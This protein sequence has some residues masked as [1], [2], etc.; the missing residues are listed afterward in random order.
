MSDVALE[1]EDASNDFYLKREKCAHIVKAA[2]SATI[3]NVLAPLLCIPMFQDEVRPAYFWAW[4]AYM[5]VVVCIRTLI[6]YRLGQRSEDI[7]D[8]TR[9][10]KQITFAVGIVGFGWGLG[11]PLMT[12]DLSMVD[13]MIY[14]YMTTAAM[15]SSMFA[16]SVNRPTFY[17]FTLPIMAPAM[18]TL[19]WPANI[20]PWPFLVGLASLYLVVLG[21]S[22]NFAK[23][24]DDSVR[25]RFRNERLYQALA[26][27]RDQ[28]VAA[29]VAKSKFI[30]IASHDLRQ[31]LQ[32]VNVNLDLFDLDTLIPKNTVLL[33][34]VKS[35]IATLNTMFDALLNMS[36]LDAYNTQPS[37]RR[38]LLAEIT[39]SVMEIA[40]PHA[41]RKSLSLT[42]SQ[43]D[44]I[45][46]GD[47][48]LLKQIL[49]NL[50]LNAIQY[51]ERGTVDVTFSVVSDRLVFRVSDTGIGISE[52]DQPHIFN[53]FYRVDRTRAQHEGLGLG[54]TIVKR[55]CHLMDATVQVESKP[56][57]GAVFTVTTPCLAVEGTQAHSFA[58][59]TK[60]LIGSD[61]TAPFT[62]KLVAVIEDDP[63]ILDAYRQMLASR[64]AQ[65]VVLTE[66]EE[67]WIAQLEHINHIDCILCDFR[68]QQH[69]GDV[70]I[71]KLREN[72]NRDI[73]ALIVTADTSPAHI[74]RFQKLNVTVLYKPVTHQTIIT[75]MAQLIARGHE[76]AVATAAH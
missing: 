43:P 68:L 47:P 75:T 30:A 62:G 1:V 57:Q 24:F 6:V 32:A 4:M 72:Y 56:D 28:S 33:Q 25:L 59:S 58:D 52:S 64:G 66:S 44:C 19:L 70:M 10:L 53:E 26:N 46:D 45:V 11:W 37:K 14:V 67:E 8:P 23:I 61:A 36:K 20:F 71:E 63:V 54:L 16:Y 49:V 13:R 73:P 5:G 38:F 22:K 39:D 21:I 42:L 17:A 50:V 74:D 31:P 41:H 55:L 51:T 34:K 65:V 9:E 3:A 12:P 7:L 18:S 29:N 69:T 40:Q 60:P 2:R 27:E 35:S 76:R 15:I 48:L